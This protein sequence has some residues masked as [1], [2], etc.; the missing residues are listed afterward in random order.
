MNAVAQITT[1]LDAFFAEQDAKVLASEIEWAL[2]RKKAIAEFWLSDERKQINDQFRLYEKLFAIAGGKTWY[3]TLHGNRKDGVIKLM[4]KNHEA[5][6][7][8]RNSNIAAKLI[9]AG[10][11]S[12]E[13]AEVAYC[14]DGFNGFFK[15]NGDRLVKIESILAG[16]YN[17]QRLHQRVLVNVK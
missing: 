12:V 6:I 16:G 9:K 4:T 8:K 5:T 15:I 2:D 11:E 17:I 1:A 13:T 10:V 3:N 14:K 7:A